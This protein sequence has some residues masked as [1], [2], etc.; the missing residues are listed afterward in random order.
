M[1]V[2]YDGED[3]FRALVEAV[4]AGHSVPLDAT[5]FHDGSANTPMVEESFG[6][7]ND[8]TQVE[9]AQFLVALSEAVHGQF[10]RRIYPYIPDKRP[11][12]PGSASN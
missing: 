11:E 10:L 12:S 2:T 5:W 4:L 6:D 3:H 1:G 7:G 9:L 8:I